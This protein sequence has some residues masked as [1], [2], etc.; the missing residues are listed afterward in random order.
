M[1]SL[2]SDGLSLNYHGTKGCDFQYVNEH[3]VNFEV[4]SGSTLI[5]VGT[6]QFGQV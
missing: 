4:K 5:H 6:S 1:P 3:I 2:S